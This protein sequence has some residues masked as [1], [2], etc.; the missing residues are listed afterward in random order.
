MRRLF[1]LLVLALVAFVTITA[2]QARKTA[3]DDR[4]VGKWSGTFDG[5]ASGTFSMAFE[6]DAAK[7]LTGTLRTS[8]NDGDGYSVTFK[9][10]QVAGPKVNLAYDAPTGEKAEVQVEAALEGPSLKG[11]WKVIDAAS[12]SVSQTGKLVGKKG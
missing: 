9:T 2:A 11:T 4:L 8:P 7:Q 10:I 5:D 12:K 1:S 3:D 6:R